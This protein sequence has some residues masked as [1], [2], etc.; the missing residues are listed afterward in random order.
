MSH[1]A[2]TIA[3]AV[4]DALNGEEFD[5]EFTAAR[6][7]LPEFQLRDMGVLHVTVVPRSDVAELLDR[8]SDIHLVGVDVAI[9]KRLSAVDNATLDI[10]LELV[11]DIAD[12]LNRRAMGNAI[13]TKTENDP[14]Y[15]PD[16]LREFR[17]FTSI[18]K[19]TY[20]VKRTPGSEPASTGT[21]S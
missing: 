6:T 20:R 3:D 10:L 1:V 16:H 4:K 21:G 14:V 18:L 11:Q 7:Q 15:A 19:F 13:W 2:I 8:H 12:F 9:Q 5:E 17:Q